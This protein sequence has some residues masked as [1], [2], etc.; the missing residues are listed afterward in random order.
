MTLT[1]RTIVVTG[2]AGALGKAV[3]GAVVAAGARVVA[4]DMNE[5]RLA[6]LAGPGVTVRRID[7][8]D[9]LSA[10]E[11]LAD[12]EADG[13]AAIAGGF[14]MGSE[15]H[16]LTDDW[17]WMQDMNVT[18]LRHT[19]AA[20]VPGMQERG[21]GSVV[22]I[23]ARNGLTGA[24]AMSAYAAAKSAVHRIT[25]SLDAEGIRANCVMPSII[26]TPANRKAM[27]D[28]DTSDWV[29]TDALAALIVFLLDD[30]SRAVRG[31]LI[32]AYGR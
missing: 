24:G 4:V 25:E 28:A 6:S 13:V 7:L 23:G 2:A 31:A 21:G 9:G 17:E 5:S 29:S 22:T 32:P 19:L 26:D 20:L 30:A 8:L 27:P 16:E 11:S 14:T 3:V 10:Q 1:G 18:T 12:F 15:A